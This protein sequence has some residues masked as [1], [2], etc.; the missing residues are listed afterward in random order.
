MQV[1]ECTLS[2]IKLILSS[3]LPASFSQPSTGSL[4]LAA[5]G[6][7]INSILVTLIASS[8]E[9]GERQRKAQE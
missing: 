8:F 9:A 2:N 6:V 7:I 5:V 3:L 1:E 4:P